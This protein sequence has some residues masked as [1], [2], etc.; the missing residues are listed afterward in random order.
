MSDLLSLVL[1]LRPL[2]PQDERP[3][4]AWWGRAAHRALLALIQQRDPAAAQTAHDGSE[5]RPFTVSTLMGR[6][7]QRRFDPQGSYLLR[8]TTCTPALSALV[9]A[10]YAPG[11]A[12]APGA[13]LELDRIPFEIAE[14][15]TRA[16]EHPWAGAADYAGLSAAALLGGSPPRRLALRFTAPTSFRRAGVHVPVPLPELVFHSLLSRWNSFAPLALPDEVQRFAAECLVLS[17]FNLQ[18]RTVQMKDEGLRIGAVGLAQYTALN[19]DRYWLGV[20]RALAQF[21][22]FGGVG[23]ATSMGM[24]QC[25]AE[26]ADQAGPE[27]QPDQP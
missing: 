24:G 2:Q 1:R 18:S 15:F 19:Y 7:V 16:E 14:V 20:L 27:A 9:G 5:L 12:L 26:D 25:R 4:P 10:L 11:G 3:L 21:A 23:A 22:F 13:V 8:F 17:R 6:F